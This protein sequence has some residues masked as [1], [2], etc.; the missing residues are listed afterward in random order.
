MAYINLTG[1]FGAARAKLPV[2]IVEAPTGIPATILSS[3]TG[4][5]VSN[6]GD[7]FLDAQ[8]NLDV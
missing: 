8:G 7:T 2:T 4:G 5:L 6:Q 1:V 3:A